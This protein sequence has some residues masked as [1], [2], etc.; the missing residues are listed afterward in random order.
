MVSGKVVV[1]K[2]YKNQEN[3]LRKFLKVIFADG[4]FISNYYK[5]AN[6]F[7]NTFASTCTAIKNSPTL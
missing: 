6:L 7:H 2:F 4:S 1:S 3:V 5:K